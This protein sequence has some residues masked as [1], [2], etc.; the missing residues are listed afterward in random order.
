M[1][2]MGRERPNIRVISDQFG[3][4][5]YTIDLCEYIS[6]VMRTYSGHGGT[7]LHYSNVTENINGVSWYD[8]ACEICRIS[9]LETKIIPITSSEY[10]QKAKRPFF[11]KMV[12]DAPLSLQRDWKTSLEAYLAN[13]SC[14]PG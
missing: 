7:I 14:E 5:T 4:P 10:P 6:Y 8:F 3:A 12:V 9:N 11:S 2:R 1:L 13:K